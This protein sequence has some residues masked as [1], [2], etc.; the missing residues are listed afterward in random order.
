MIT[1]RTPEE[2]EKI[3]L[4]SKLTADTLSLLEKTVRPGISTLELDR[5]A[6]EYIRSN[7]GIPSCKGYEG[8]PASLCTSVNDMVVHGIPSAKKILRKGDII[9]I[10]LVVELNGYMGDSCITIPVGHT[11]KKNLQLI[12]V[13]EQALFAG[14]K[15]AVPGNHVGDIGYAVEKTVKPYG[16]GVLREYVG[17]GIGTD[18]HEDPEVPNYGTPGHGPRLEEGMVI[19]IEPMITMGSPDILTLRDGWGVVTADGKPAAHIEHTVAITKDGPKILTL[20]S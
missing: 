11:N 1:I 18:M 7:G 20:R 15:Q 2:I 3:A 6:E 13:T 17:H 14:I 19:C 4:A 9:S 12:E 8:Y 16:Y 10:D 5:I